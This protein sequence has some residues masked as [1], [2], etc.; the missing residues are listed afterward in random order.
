MKFDNTCGNSVSLHDSQ[1]NDALW[2]LRE[3]RMR[4]G[5]LYPLWWRNNYYN[6]TPAPTFRYWTFKKK[7]A[8]APNDR[9]NSE[10]IHEIDHQV[11]IKNVEVQGRVKRIQ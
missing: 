2:Q 7:H 3:A 10:R 9:S 1:K 5:E 8:H 6:E 4:N 11:I